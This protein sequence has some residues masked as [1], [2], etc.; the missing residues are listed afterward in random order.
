MAIILTDTQKVA[1]SIQ[2]VDAKGNPALVDGIPTWSVSDP[3][4]LLLVVASD[5]MSATI[6]TVGKLGNGQVVVESDA[7]LGEGFIPLQGILDVTV[8][9]GQAVALNIVTGLPEEI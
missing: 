2:P 3:E 5:G 7:D 8:V 6:F 1:A 9:A 4:L